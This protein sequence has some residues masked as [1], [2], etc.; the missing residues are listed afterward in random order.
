MGVPT[1]SYFTGGLS[2]GP[3]SADVSVNLDTNHG[4]HTQRLVELYKDFVSSG[5]SVKF[6][7]GQVKK[8]SFSPFPKSMVPDLQPPSDTKR[9]GGKWKR[10][11]KPYRPSYWRSV[12]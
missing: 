7:H 1:V 8:S 11:K 3:N 6:N 10:S 2:S 9:G 4:F 5:V 12:T